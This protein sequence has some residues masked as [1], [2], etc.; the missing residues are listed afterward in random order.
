MSTPQA[1]EVKVTS[2]SNAAKFYVGLAI[3]LVAS[4]ATTAHSPLTASGVAQIVVM[5]LT[6]VAGYTVPYSP[7]WW[8]SAKAYVVTAGAILSAIVPFLVQYVDTNEWRN[9]TETEWVVVTLAVVK[10]VAMVVTT[11][12][13]PMVYREKQAD[14]STDITTDLPEATTPED[15]VAEHRAPELVSDAPTTTPVDFQLA[16]PPSGPVKES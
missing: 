7:K 9:L 15:H 8:T 12:T 10:A 5:V 1:V 6:L 3:A 11:N 14:G 16:E 2:F 13:K 4:I